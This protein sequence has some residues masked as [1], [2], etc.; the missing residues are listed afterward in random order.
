MSKT[1][2]ILSRLSQQLRLGRG[3]RS[4]AR[5]DPHRAAL[6]QRLRSWQSARLQRSHADL[7]TDARF[8][9]AARFFVT[10]LYSPAGFGKLE[11]EVDRVVPVMARLLPAAA[12]ETVA[13]AVELDALSELLDAA[14][15]DA[16]GAA[17]MELDGRAYGAAYRQLGRRGDRERQIRLVEDL[18]RA[19]AHLTRLPFIAGMLAMMRQ[20]ARL[21]RL[22]E[23]QDFLERGFTAFKATRD[24]DEF[25]RRIVTKEH[26]LMEAVFAGDDTLLGA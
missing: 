17:V 24:I 19:L 20:P 4:E 25:L 21:A 11:G 5:A 18:G 13:D 15:I 1:Q 3:L 14:M 26:R 9:R 22:D 8:E 10:D 2:Q 12:L 7:L 23:L 6:R 16:L